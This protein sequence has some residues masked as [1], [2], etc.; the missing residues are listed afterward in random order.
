MCLFVARLLFVLFVLLVDL[1]WFCFVGWLFLAIIAIYL[2]VFL[3]GHILHEMDD[4]S[5]Q[6]TVPFP[7]TA[8]ELYWPAP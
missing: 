7:I 5:H 2:Y 4:G 8:H 1:D 3:T 6:H